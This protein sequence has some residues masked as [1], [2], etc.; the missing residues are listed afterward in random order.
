MK[1]ILLVGTPRKMASGVSTHINQLLASPLIN[2]FKFDHFIIGS[3]G[4]HES[5][6]NKIKRYIFSPINLVVKIINF[7]PDIVHLNPSMDFK[8]FFRDAAY[9]FVAKLLGRKIV[10]Q[11]HAGLKPQVFFNKSSWLFWPRK[12]VLQAADVVILLTKLE[13]EHA[14]N[15]CNFKILK[16]VPNAI[17]VAAFASNI[18]DKFNNSNEITLVY[19]GRLVVEKGIKEAIEALALLNQQ[20]YKNLKFKIAGAGSYE[21]SLK[22]L[23]KE[24]NIS[25]KVEFMGPIFGDKKMQFWSN[26]NILVF[27][28]Y[29][30]GLP[31][32]LLEALASGTP[33]ITTRVG[34]I[35]EIIEDGVQGL[36]VEEKSPEAIARAIKKMVSNISCLKSM[37]QE[38]VKRA[39]ERFSIERLSNEIGDIYENI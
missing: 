20:D 5:K 14:A 15:F 29:F 39:N 6:F 4:S 23:S 16:I 13:F 22:N 8:G 31:Y 27:P 32:T 21:Q 30:E 19:I 34:G 18:T 25:D 12:L 28:S 1:K 11:L 2:K 37:S 38:C 9:L 26:A 7:Q 36:F 35:P 24:L 33:I 10:L 3:C 17:D